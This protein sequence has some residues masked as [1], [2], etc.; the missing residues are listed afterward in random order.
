M[1]SFKN[2]FSFL[3][4]YFF[5]YLSLIPQEIQEIEKEAKT[6]FEIIYEVEQS[7]RLPE[8]LNK[9]RMVIINKKG[10]TLF[11][12]IKHYKKKND[13]LFIFENSLRGKV[14]SLLLQ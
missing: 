8:G 3:V 7:M 1:I 10:Q 13:S 11:Y 4:F 12:E 14:L 2:W 6:S 5:L 9:A